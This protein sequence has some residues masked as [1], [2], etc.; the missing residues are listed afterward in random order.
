MYIF[1]HNYIYMNDLEILNIRTK[2]LYH[3]K[4]VFN[5]DITK[6]TLDYCIGSPSRAEA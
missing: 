5:S 3:L 6:E 4:K 2:Y 1:V